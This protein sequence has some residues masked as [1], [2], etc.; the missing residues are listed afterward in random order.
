MLETLTKAAI[1]D[2]TPISIDDAL[3][4]NDKYSVDQLCDAADAIRLKWSGNDVHTCSIINAR[5]GKCGEDCKWCA[6]SAHHNTGV[7]EYEYVGHDEWMSGY[8]AC[9]DHGVGSYSMVTSGRRVAPKHMDVFCRMLREAHEEGGVNLCAS[10]GLLE[11]EELQ[12]LYDAGVR[13]YHCNLETSPSYFKKLCTTHTT[14]DK[15]RTIR[16]AR[17]V[18]LEVCSGGI[19]GMGETM[20]DRLEMVQLSREA[21]ASS[22]P[23]N[24][25]I[26]IPGTPLE[27][28]E[29]LSEEVIIRT[30]ALM[31]FVA[32]KCTIHFAGGRAKLSEAAVRRMLRGGSNGAMMGDLLTTVGNNTDED[33][34]LFAALDYNIRQSRSNQA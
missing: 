15:L 24:I 21:G 11:K 31:R 13:K 32:P 7:T 2:G 10:M 20:R 4:L 26:P 12:K 17:E 33:R 6:Q 9:R 23:V 29:P 16:M 14:E 5:S 27:N 25:L 18:G 28:M 30:V 8:R 19:I 3:L 22:I 34:R 1:E